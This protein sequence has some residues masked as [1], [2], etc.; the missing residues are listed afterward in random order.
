MS[1]DKPP[2]VDHD[3]SLGLSERNARDFGFWSFCPD[4][5]RNFQRAGR[6]G[7]KP[8]YWESFTPQAQCPRCKAAEMS[9]TPN[10]EGGR[11]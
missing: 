6:P 11:W 2:Y 5:K 3:P 4:C 7:E 9:T 1:A 10:R 8:N